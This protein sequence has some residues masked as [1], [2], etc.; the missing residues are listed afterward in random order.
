[1]SPRWTAQRKKK[2]VDAY[3]LGHDVSE[4]LREHNIGLEE[5]TGWLSRHMVHGLEGLR[6]RA[7]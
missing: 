3:L 7:P 2:L 1:M 5:F 4:I 6:A